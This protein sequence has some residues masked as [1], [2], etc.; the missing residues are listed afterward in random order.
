MAFTKIFLLKDDRRNSQPVYYDGLLLLGRISN[1]NSSQKNRLL[2]ALEEAK[3]TRI[4]RIDAL[5]AQVSNGQAS[6]SVL[7]A[8]GISRLIF[9]TMVSKLWSGKKEVRFSSRR[10]ILFILCQSHDY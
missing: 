9:C 7:S 6:N 4:N 3:S 2:E 5:S 10:C 1:E 8:D